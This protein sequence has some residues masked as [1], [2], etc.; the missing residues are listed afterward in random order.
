MD[1]RSNKYHRKKNSLQPQTEDYHQILKLANQFD[2]AKKQLVEQ[3]KSKM[4]SMGISQSIKE[5]TNNAN[6]QSIIKTNS[7]PNSS[8]QI[9]KSSPS[10][11]KIDTKN[12]FQISQ[13]NSNSEAEIKKL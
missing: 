12:C 9:I 13:E 11:D 3:H 8:M 10:M 6:I 7:R 1:Q 4:G 5:A 2:Q